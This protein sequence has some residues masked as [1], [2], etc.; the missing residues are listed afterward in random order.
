MRRVNVMKSK[1]GLNP[2]TSSAH[3]SAALGD[4]HVAP[5]IA[6]AIVDLLA[7]LRRRPARGSAGELVLQREQRR[8]V[9]LG[10]GA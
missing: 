8:A 2:R 9:V 10:E 1:T 6:R 5:P 4:D 7:Q 3:L